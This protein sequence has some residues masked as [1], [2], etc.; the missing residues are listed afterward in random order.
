MID[1]HSKYD[2][3]HKNVIFYALIC[4]NNRIIVCSNFMLSIN[5]ELLDH[6]IFEY[7]IRDIKI[8]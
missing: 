8:Y 5:Y 6:M 4:I 2:N 1:M 7:L 3:V